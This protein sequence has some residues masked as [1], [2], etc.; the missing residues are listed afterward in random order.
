MTAAIPD[1]VTDIPPKPS[2]GNEKDETA[3][4]KVATAPDISIR[5]WD[6][7]FQT[8]KVFKSNHKGAED[9]TE[10]REKH[11]KE[12]AWKLYAFIRSI[13]RLI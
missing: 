9:I 10:I 5:S 13:F 2:E 7:F 8:V 6:V 11:T 12:Q 3:S 1:F 4:Q